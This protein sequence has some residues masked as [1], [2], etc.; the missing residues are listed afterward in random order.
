MTGVSEAEGRSLPRPIPR[1]AAEAI[2]DRLRVLGQPVRVRIIDR[3]H[4][5]GEQT[6]GGLA[7]LLGER[8]NNVSQ[9]LA[10]L[11]VAGTVSRRH[12]GREAWYRLD[13]DVAVL[14]EAIA[15]SLASEAARRGRLIDPL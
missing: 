11:R 6:V 2:A 9:H 3:L 1:G 13:E 8:L 7:G 12:R 14:Y 4:L 5:D 10:V 15:R